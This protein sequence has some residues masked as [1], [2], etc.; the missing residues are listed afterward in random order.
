MPFCRGKCGRRHI[1]MPPLPRFWAWE[2]VFDPRGKSVLRTGGETE[3]CSRT[4]PVT[5]HSTTTN[6]P[7]YGNVAGL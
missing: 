4:S 2:V 5:I 6:S 7:F 3:S 1:V